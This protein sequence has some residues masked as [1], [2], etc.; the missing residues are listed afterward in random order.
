MARFI[1]AEQI[2]LKLDHDLSIEDLDIVFKLSK[3]IKEQPAVQITCPK[4]HGVGIYKIP[5]YN[6]DTWELSKMSQD[7]ICEL[8]HGSG[9]LDVDFYEELQ[10]KILE[11]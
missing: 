10:R 5:V 9:K 3:L 7:C 4:C 8:C 11:D 2:V 6:E 1:D